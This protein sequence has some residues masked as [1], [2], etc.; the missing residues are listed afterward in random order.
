LRI[1]YHNH[2]DDDDLHNDDHDNGELDMKDDRRQ[3]SLG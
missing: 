3:S 1:D 2:D